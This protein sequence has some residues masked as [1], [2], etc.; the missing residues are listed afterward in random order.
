MAPMA[1]F[2]PWPRA[3]AGIAAIVGKCPRRAS[4][5]H[6][7]DLREE[8]FMR[9]DML[10]GNVTYR[11]CQQLNVVHVYAHVTRILYVLRNA[12]NLCIR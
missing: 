9:R 7:R 11:A 10:F 4:Q 1:R 5:S 6:P 2:N 8:L 12:N 3:S